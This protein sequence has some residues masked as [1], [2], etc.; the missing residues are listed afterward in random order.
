MTTAAAEAAFRFAIEVSVMFTVADPLTDGCPECHD[1][2]A[3]A[4]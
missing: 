4:G 1:S 2:S 3:L